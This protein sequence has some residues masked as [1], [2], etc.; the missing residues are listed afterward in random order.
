MSRYSPYSSSTAPPTPFHLRVLSFP[1]SLF[2]TRLSTAE[3]ALAWLAPH[4]DWQ[5]HRH[6]PEVVRELRW[7][8]DEAQRRSRWG[9]REGRGEDEDSD[10]LE[11]K[12]LDWS[13]PDDLSELS[14]VKL[15]LLPV[16]PDFHPSLVEPARRVFAARRE[17]DL[18]PV[19]SRW[20]VDGL[21]PVHLLERWSTIFVGSVLWDLS[22]AEVWS[23]LSL[24][25]LPKPVAIKRHRKTPPHDDR[26]ALTFVAYE[27]TNDALRACKS[28]DNTCYLHEG[29]RIQ[30]MAR[31]AERPAKCATWD[32]M[33]TSEEF[34][35]RYHP[36]YAQQ[37]DTQHQHDYPPRPERSRNHPPSPLASHS[38]PPST[39]SSKP[40]ES[41][42]PARASTDAL[43][44]LELLKPLTCLSVENLPRDLTAADLRAYLPP[45]STVGIA[46]D[47]PRYSSSLATAYL[48]FSSVFVAKTV[49]LAFLDGRAYR[50]LPLPK[51]TSA[52]RARTEPWRWSEMDE[53]FVKAKDG[54][55]PGGAKPFPTSSSPSPAKSTSSSTSHSHSSTTPPDT[56]FTTEDARREEMLR[57]QLLSRKRTRA[58]LA[59]SASS[60]SSADYT[61]RKLP[62]PALPA[63]P[64][65]PASVPGPRTYDA[66]RPPSRPRAMRDSSVAA[67]SS[68][69][70]FVAFPF[71]AQ[72]E[73]QAQK[74]QPACVLGGMEAAGL[75]K[76]PSGYRAENG[77]ADA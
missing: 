35:R 59:S 55:V 61:P 70:G 31:M 44:P 14:S 8:R 64:A 54:P 69:E 6:F 19:E 76:R 20:N 49:A 21:V 15:A 66:F 51:M 42:P 10:V 73:A 7:R 75:P 53:D 34:R 62:A 39:A 4:P 71:S 32:W 52:E 16:H 46:L 22:T 38:S 3:L 12:E 5:E 11:N 50:D 30:L 18:R 77:G 43:V 45:S 57:A 37:Q 58:N 60:A 28:L 27:S 25:H 72:G 23:I 26:F 68:A 17:R 24:P 65:A 1:L 13:V 48:L 47:V 74:Q 9:R 29:A 36:G 56:K 63:P 67:F 2:P 33:H 40:F 41:L